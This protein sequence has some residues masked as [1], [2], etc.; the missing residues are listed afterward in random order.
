MA[1]CLA[2]T[3]RTAWRYS[4]YLATHTKFGLNHSTMTN[5]LHYVP[6]C[7][8]LSCP[9]LCFSAL[10]CAVMFQVICSATR[11]AKCKCPITGEKKVVRVPVWN[12][13][14][15]NVSLMAVGSR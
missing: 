12:W 7:A 1:K 13:V 9:V 10:C 6:C 2:A 5:P 15:A 4:C 14:V 8:A 3:K 11:N